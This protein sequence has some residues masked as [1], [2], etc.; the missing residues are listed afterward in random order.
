[1]FNRFYRLEIHIH[2]WLVF[3]TQLVNCYPMDEGTIVTPKPKWS[4]SVFNRVHWLEIQSVMLVISTP[5]M[6]CCPSIFSL[7]SPPPSQSKCT[8]YRDSVWLWGVGVGVLSCVVDHILQ[9]FNTPFLTR[10]RTYKISMP[11]Q[12]KMTSKDNIRGLVSLKSMKTSIAKKE[13]YVSSLAQSDCS[14]STSW[15]PVNHSLY[16]WQKELWKSFFELCILNVLFYF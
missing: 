1:M 5:L 4:F 15:V 2:S 9:E 11:P 8:V 12:T 7:T 14:H 10:F 13:I 6:Y 16:D 3:S